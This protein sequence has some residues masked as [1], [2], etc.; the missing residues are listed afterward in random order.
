MLITSWRVPPDGKEQI[1]PNQREIVLAKVRLEQ[2]IP[3]F[4]NT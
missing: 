4:W 2:N 1:A 3:I